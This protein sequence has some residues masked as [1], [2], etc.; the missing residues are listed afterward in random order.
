MGDI[1]YVIDRIENNIVV[2]ED[3]DNNII[4]VEKNKFP[5]SIKEG[6]VIEII[7][8]KYVIDK[9]KTINK[10]IKPSKN[11]ED[12]IEK[13]YL[14]ISVI[15]VLFFVIIGIKLFTLQ[16]LSYDEYNLKLTS[17]TDTIIE[18]SS[19]PR[20]R[21]YDNFFKICYNINRMVVIL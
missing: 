21:I 18:G 9:V 6:D 16:I 7:D 15:L 2:L 8:N 14:F 10:S 13:R 11:L 17:A 20:G 4:E 1:M 3:N 19:A 12:I 5:N